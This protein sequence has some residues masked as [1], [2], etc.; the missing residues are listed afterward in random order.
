[1]QNHKY[2]SRTRYATLS[3]EPYPPRPAPPQNSRPI[4]VCSCGP[5]RRA[6]LTARV[7]RDAYAFYSRCLARRRVTGFTELAVR[8]SVRHTIAGPLSYTHGYVAGGT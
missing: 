4:V 5:F 7:A 1:M 2:L 6:K 8:A 3:S